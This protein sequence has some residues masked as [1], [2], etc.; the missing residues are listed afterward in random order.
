MAIPT[1]NTERTMIQKALRNRSSFVS[2]VKS[3]R[4]HTD[5]YSV[6]RAVMKGLQSDQH[7]NRSIRGY[8][9]LESNPD[10][11]VHGTGLVAARRF[12]AGESIITMNGRFLIEDRRV[13]DPWLLSMVTGPDGAY[14]NLVLDTETGN[15]ARFINSAKGTGKGP[16]VEM[17]SYGAAIVIKA[18]ADIPYGVELLAM[19]TVV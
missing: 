16:N 2:K 9:K 19:Y 15:I 1:D 7:P 17:Y 5:D 18:I 14:N 13:R 6:R 11:V 12:K 3:R 4:S 10:V 8:L